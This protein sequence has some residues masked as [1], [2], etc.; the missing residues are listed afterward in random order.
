MRRT[1]MAAAAAVLV[2]GAGSV[3]QVGPALVRD[4]AAPPRGGTSPPAPS[5]ARLPPMAR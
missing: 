5:T 1:M 2:M 4:G 3:G